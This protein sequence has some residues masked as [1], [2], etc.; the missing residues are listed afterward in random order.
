MYICTCICVRQD[1]PNSFRE[2]QLVPDEMASCDDEP[3]RRGDLWL[4]Y[5]VIFRSYI[6][7]STILYSTLLY[8][9]LLYYTIIYYTS[10]DSKCPQ[11]QADWPTT[12]RRSDELDTTRLG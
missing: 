11:L 7:Y 9:T 12:A 1:G 5:Y 6:V 2:C 3:L 4:I 10:S 8:Y